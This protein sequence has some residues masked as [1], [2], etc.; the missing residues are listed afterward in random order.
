MRIAVVSDGLNVAEHIMRCRN[1]NCY[2]TRSLQVCDSKNVP[3]E[4][5]SCNDYARLMLNMGVD[6]VI[7][8][9]VSPTCRKAFEAYDIEIVEGACGNALEA[10]RN[11]TSWLLSEA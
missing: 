1:I 6:V 11:Y 2:T 8:S 3:A 7:C 9:S 5:L 4:G 10:A